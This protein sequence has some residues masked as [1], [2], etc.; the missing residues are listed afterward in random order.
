MNVMTKVVS[1]VGLLLVMEQ[2][3]FTV[4]DRANTRVEIL[5]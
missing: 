5:D 3:G 1:V 2:R 4:T